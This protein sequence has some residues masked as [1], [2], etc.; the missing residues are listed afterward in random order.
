MPNS[1]SWDGMRQPK[2]R[3]SRP[4]QH[5]LGRTS[6]HRPRSAP[7]APGV[8]PCTPVHPRAPPLSAETPRAAG[9]AK[10]HVVAEVRRDRESRTAKPSLRLCAWRA[11]SPIGAPP[12]S[13]CRSISP[14][15]LA[16]TAS[17]STK[18][19]N[20][21]AQSSKHP[22]TALFPNRLG[23]RVWRNDA[24]CAVSDPFTKAQPGDSCWPLLVARKRGRQPLRELDILGE[25]QLIDHPAHTA[26]PCRHTLSGFMH[27]RTHMQGGCWGGQSYRPRKSNSKRKRIAFYSTRQRPF[28]R[29]DAPPGTFQNDDPE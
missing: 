1:M 8:P 27:I 7:G 9:R 13:G 10:K 21:E 3:S 4:R 12:H 25:R 11:S 20:C 28:A 23:E 18:A 24:K 22:A 15:R 19:S 16:N 29:R 2:A 14:L 17:V 26:K 5:S 6:F